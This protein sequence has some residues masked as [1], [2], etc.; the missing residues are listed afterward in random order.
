MSVLAII[1]AQS[2][3]QMT[4]CWQITAILITLPL[5]V[6]Q[7]LGKVW[8]WRFCLIKY[9]HN[10]PFNEPGSFGISRLFFHAKVTKFG[11]KVGLKML[12]NITSVFS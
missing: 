8:S 5:Y 7:D 10:G 9:A 11:T 4:L 6:P 12:I 1:S 3:S 2:W